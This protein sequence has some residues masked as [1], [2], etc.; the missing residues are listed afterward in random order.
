MDKPTMSVQSQKP[1][2]NML[3]ITK[4]FMSKID[5]VWDST[6]RSA[7]LCEVLKYLRELGY[8]HTSGGNNGACGDEFAVAAVAGMIVGQAGSPKFLNVMLM[9]FP[10]QL[11]EFKG[12]C[13]LC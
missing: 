5:E 12:M 10:V 4:K 13:P 1:L 6:N 7:V 9:A 8:Y 11:A 2:D 3:P